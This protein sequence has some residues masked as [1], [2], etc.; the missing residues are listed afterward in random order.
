MASIARSPIPTRVQQRCVCDRRAS[1]I[2]K[3]TRCLPEE[4]KKRTVEGPTDDHIARK[5][6]KSSAFER[7]IAC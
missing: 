7:L 6:Q 2:S 5:D 1:E 3:R 4:M